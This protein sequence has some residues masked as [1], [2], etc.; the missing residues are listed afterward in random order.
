M[1]AISEPISGLANFRSDLSKPTSQQICS[2]VS[3]IRGEMGLGYSSRFIRTEVAHQVF[4]ERPEPIKNERKHEGSRVKE[5][6]TRNDDFM[7]GNESPKQIGNVKEY[8]DCFN[9]IINQVQL[10]E[11]Y[12]LSCFIEGLKEDIQTKVKMFN[13]TTLYHAYCLAKLEEFVQESIKKS[14]KFKVDYNSQLELPTVGTST[15]VQTGGVGRDGCSNLKEIEAIKVKQAEV[16]KKLVECVSVDTKDSD[17]VGTSDIMEESGHK[18]LI[19]QDCDVNVEAKRGFIE[20]NFNEVVSG[21]KKVMM[22]THVKSDVGTILTIYEVTRLVSGALKGGLAAANSMGYNTLLVIRHV[23]HMDSDVMV[24]VFISQNKQEYGGSQVEGFFTNW[25]YKKKGVRRWLVKWKWKDAT[26]KGDPCCVGYG[27]Y[28][29]TVEAMVRE[30]VQHCMKPMADYP[31][32]E[33]SF[34]VGDGVY[35]KS[36]SYRQQSVAQR[37]NQKWAAKY[38]SPH[39]ILSKVAGVAYT[40]QLPAGSSI[41]PTV[42][43]DREVDPT[44]LEPESVEDATCNTSKIP[45]Q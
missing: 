1:L 4:D 40:L 41:H 25:L 20:T 5:S 12:S 30:K 15:N 16:D 2:V 44:A 43:V 38:F 42:H 27:K 32:T 19:G 7:I 8:Y 17:K 28:D 33:R 18:F 10:P 39:M 29:K 24:V 22:K 23:W 35:L 6:L 34:Q 31:R 9:K 11:V 36:Q 3:D 14:Q 37:S 45:V 21:K 13:P 26:K